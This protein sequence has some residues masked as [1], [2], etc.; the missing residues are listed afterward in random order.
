MRMVAFGGIGRER[1]TA[2]IVRVQTVIICKTPKKR[3][4]AVRH[5]FEDL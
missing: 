1:H 5:D 4:W 2:M 3:L